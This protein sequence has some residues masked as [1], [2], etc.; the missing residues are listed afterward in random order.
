[1]LSDSVDV[2]SRAAWRVFLSV[3]LHACLL[4]SF[5]FF[6]IAAPF[7][8]SPKCSVVSERLHAMEPDEADRDNEV[9][10]THRRT[11]QTNMHPAHE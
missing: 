1:M 9:Y 6:F 3:C 2:D 10:I 11:R 7:D 8:A 4:T 5:F